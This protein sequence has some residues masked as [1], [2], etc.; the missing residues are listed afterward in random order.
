[1]PIFKRL[2]LH[3]TEFRPSACQS[4][5]NV[6]LL[7]IPILILVSEECV[8]IQNFSERTAPK[9]E[10]MHVGLCRAGSARIRLNDQFIESVAGEINHADFGKGAMMHE[11]EKFAILN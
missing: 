5:P 1:M 2:L 11:F 6:K 10:N 8:R 4:A 3:E 7:F 9:I